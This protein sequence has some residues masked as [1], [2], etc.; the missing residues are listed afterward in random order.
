MAAVPTCRGVDAFL[1]AVGTALV[2][3][4]GEGLHLD[5]VQ[6]GG[7]HIRHRGHGLLHLLLQH[8]LLPGKGAKEERSD[9]RDLHR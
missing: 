6:G 3:G 7:G 2:V 5:T 9:H 8:L 1:L 4:L